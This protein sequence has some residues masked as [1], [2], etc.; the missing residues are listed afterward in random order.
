M[1]IYIYIYI[2]LL[3]Y[4]STRALQALTVVD[5]LGSSDGESGVSLETKRTDE[6]LE[7]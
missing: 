5:G 7:E 6:I 3:K 1:Y 4:N 2:S